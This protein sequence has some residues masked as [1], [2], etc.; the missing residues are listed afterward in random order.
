MPSY[1]FDAAYREEVGLSDG[2]TA[3]LRLLRGDEHDK[4][5]LRRGFERLSPASRYRRFLAPKPRLSEREVDYLTEIDGVDHVAIGAVRRLD[6]G[7]QGLG[8]AR[9]V[10]LDDGVA[11]PAVAVVD[12]A[13]GLGLGTLLMNR[14]VEAALERGITR[15]SCDFLASNDVMRNVL[16]EIAESIEYEQ[17]GS[18]VTAEL[19]LRPIRGLKRVL[20]HVARQELEQVPRH[21]GTREAS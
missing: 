15:F 7:E 10:R 4:A 21:G 17:E 8:I 18:I 5:L 20:A 13:Q 16:E 12:D 3:V 14:L 6:G 2:T 1:R 9:F 19:T 11:E